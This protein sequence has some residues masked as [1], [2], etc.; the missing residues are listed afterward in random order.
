MLL[1]S[2]P[3]KNSRA[4]RCRSELNIGA[5]DIAVLSTAP[6]GPATGQDGAVHLE[7]DDPDR[8]AAALADAGA[9]RGSLVGLAVSPL[10]AVGL[11]VGEARF[12]LAGDQVAVLLARLDEELRPR[13]VCWSSGTAAAL[14]AH[15]VQL[16]TCWDVAAA[17]R[18]LHGG[19]RADPAR[20]WA[21][22]H[23]LDHRRLPAMGQ[24]DLLG[25]EGDGGGDPEQPVRPDGYLRPEW[26]AGGWSASSQSLAEWAGAALTAATEQQARLTALREHGEVQGDPLATARSES[27]AELL[28]AELAHDGLPIDVAVA[29]SLIA[30]LVGP[31]AADEAEAAAGRA[32]RD[33]EVLRHLPPGSGSDLRNPADVKAL[34]RRLGIDVPDTRAWR[35]EQM[36]DVHPVID[37]LLA[38][39]KAER[40]ATT[41]GYGWM[42]ANV[43]ADGRLRG[44]WSASDGAAGRMTAGAGLHNLPAELRPMVVA[45][46]GFVFVRA[47]LG[48]IEPRVLAAV[49]G[50]P[51]LCR[52][53]QEDDLYAPVAKRLGV[54]R[55]VAKVAVL[56]AMYGQTSG[57]AGQA[58]RGMETGYPVAMRY[59]ADAAQA[60]VEGRELRTY[61]GRLIRMFDIPEEADHRAVAAGRGRYARN[62]MVQGAAAEL[63]KVWAVTVRA[64]GRALDARIVLCL[65]DEL[66]VHVPAA[67]ADATVQLL[68]DCLAEAAHRW[69]PRTAQVRFVAEISIVRSWADAK[70]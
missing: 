60:G 5:R 46:D 70:G 3:K 66:L 6:P 24:L 37:A 35:L 36:R 40:V 44:E 18:L 22:L 58:L 1:T 17:H 8:A 25:G 10:G 15:G 49:S 12:S 65:H 53:T 55:P 32:R 2:S 39:R 19:W 16:A 38:W 30:S 14:L 9:Q 7:L 20:V 41:F 51:A 31:R 13:W 50:D 23:G 62:A 47:D 45:D 64:R 67:G 27:T 63:F 61:G 21:L 33:A 28:C 59:L 26:V 42:D 43:G 68:H 54:E 29:A 4:L 48:Q 69:Q 11:A 57:T 56:A 34:L 52:A